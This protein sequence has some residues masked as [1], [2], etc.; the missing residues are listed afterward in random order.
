MNAGDWKTIAAVRAYET[1]SNFLEMDGAKGDTGY[2]S[3]VTVV[4]VLKKVHQKK[5]NYI[6]NIDNID[7]V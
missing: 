7:T 5:K 6:D 3:I 4:D 2:N 1:W